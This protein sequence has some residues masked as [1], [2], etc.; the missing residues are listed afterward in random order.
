MKNIGRRLRV[1][2]N[3]NNEKTGKLVQVGD[4]SIVVNTEQKGK[5]RKIAYVETEINFSDIKKTNVLVSFK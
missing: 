1:L 3:D 5:S 2:L 4:H